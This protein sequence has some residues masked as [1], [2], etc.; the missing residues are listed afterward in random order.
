VV[1]AGNDSGDA[2][3]KS[4]ASA[5]SALTVGSSD[6]DYS[7]SSDRVSYFSNYGTCVD[8]WAPGSNILSAYHTSDIASA[9]KSGTSMVRGLRSCL[10]PHF[11]P[12]GC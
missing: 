8:I 11:G 2:C 5:V 6:F 12:L 10:R 3:N 9:T 1:A 7:S 4:P